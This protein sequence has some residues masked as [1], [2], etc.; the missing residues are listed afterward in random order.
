[1][2]DEGEDCASVVT[3]LSA[4]RGALDRV[5]FII[6]SHRMEECLLKK[7]QCGTDEGKAL[8]EAMSLF[9]KLS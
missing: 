8:E 1:M 7:M 2:I 9:L 3:Q 6:V 5:G 4:V